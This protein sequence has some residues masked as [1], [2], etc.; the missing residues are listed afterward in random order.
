MGMLLL[1]KYS[2]SA[3]PIAVRPA[4][5]SSKRIDVEPTRRSSGAAVPAGS[6]VYGADSGSLQQEKPDSGVRL[7]LFLLS[8][9]QSKLIVFLPSYYTISLI[10]GTVAL[11]YGSVPLYKMVRFESAII[12]K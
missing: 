7:P 9:E 6:T 3:V 11:S 10:L 4:Q 5:S 12:I 1:P 8:A 2:N